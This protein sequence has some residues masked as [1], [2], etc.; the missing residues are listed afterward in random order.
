MA[1]Y[2]IGDVQGCLTALQE[3]LR[4]IR[5][6]P[7]RDRLWFTGDLVNRGPQSLE[8]LR[9]VRAL[10]ANAVS[11]LGNHD[12]HLLA[13]AAG[14]AKLKTHDTFK[15][16]LGAADRDELL[17]WLRSQPLLHHDTQLGFTMV[18]AGLLPPW[19]LAQAQRL[20]DEVHEALRRDGAIFAHMYGD[21]PDRWSQTL[22]GYD[23]LRVIVNAF[24]RLRFC[25]L[26]GGMD[27]HHTGAPG[28][29]P[30]ELLP[31]YA[32]PGRQSAGG[33][34][35]FGH[36]STL[37]VFDDQNVIGIDSGCVW[38]GSLTAV[39]MDGPDREFFQVRCSQQRKPRKD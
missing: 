38:G 24:T 5:F 34:I 12:L 28:T 3:L 13:V 15:P 39:R 20:A 10:G 9:F 16:V 21:L 32:V 35:V 27:L 7:A 4:T 29:Q 17:A 37:G 31:W 6:D 1:V 23:R 2:A 30:A 19:G 8:T 11:V 18:H 25:D 22:R 14:D 33:R 36:W 26:D